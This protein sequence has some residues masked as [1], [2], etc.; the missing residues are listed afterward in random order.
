MGLYQPK[1]EEFPPSFDGQQFRQFQ[2]TWYAQFPWLEYFKEI[3][4]AYCFVCFLF[5]EKKAKYPKFTIEGFRSWKRINNGERCSF[6]H[7]EDGLNSHHT[8]PM[9]KWGGLKNPSQH[10][11]KVMNTQ[12][13]QQILQ[14]RLRFMPQ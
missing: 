10:I 7:H 13:S 5:Y 9:L 1:L 4:V 6:L 11:D 8:K 14:N 12:L 2:Y 3:D